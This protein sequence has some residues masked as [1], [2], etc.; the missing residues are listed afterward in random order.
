MKKRLLVFLIL[1]CIV[2]V[3]PN[4]SKAT[5]K[6][7]FLQKPVSKE[8]L[9]GALMQRLAPAEEPQFLGKHISKKVLKETLIQRLTEHILIVVG[10]NWNRGNEKIL[11]IK[12]ENSRTYIVTLQLISVEGPH[13]PPYIEETITFKLEGYKVKPIDYFNRVIPENEWHTLQI[14]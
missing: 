3:V 4:S 9:K 10:R 2:S 5:E 12:K 11:E 1:I 14:R 7:Q 6:P 13:N 8:L